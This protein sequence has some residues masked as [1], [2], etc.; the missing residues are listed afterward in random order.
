MPLTWDVST[1]K[2]Q[3]FL[4]THP[5]DRAK[6]AADPSAKVRWN[7]IT[8][9]LVWHS[10][11]CGFGR[12]AESNWQEVYQRIHFYEQAVGALVAHHETGPRYITPQDV[13]D[14]I[15]L[16]TN[17][18]TLTKAKF[19]SKVMAQANDEASARIRAFLKEREAGELPE[20]LTIQL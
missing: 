9:T 2:N 17:A 11:I 8:E 19:A 12:I 14:H 10:M 6:R 4:T 18:S 15:G 5:A 3:D 13:F 1:I 7:P 20:T 16:R